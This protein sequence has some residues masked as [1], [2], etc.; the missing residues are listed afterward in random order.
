MESEDTTSNMYNY[1]NFT[2]INRT[3]RGFIITF[4]IENI[5]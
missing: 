4:D 5:H 3:S 2:Y 1:I